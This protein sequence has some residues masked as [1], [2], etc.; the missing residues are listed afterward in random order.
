MELLNFAKHRRRMLARWGLLGASPTGLT[1]DYVQQNP[2]G[3]GMP[4]PSEGAPSAASVIVEA[5]RLAWSLA[6]RQVQRMTVG[7]GRAKLVRRKMRGCVPVRVRPR[8]YADANGKDW[9]YVLPD[10]ALEL[11]SAL[12]YYATRLGV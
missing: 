10:L 4:V 6:R 5:R 2:S 9:T 3:Q 8:E 12:L 1:M 11:E 7:S